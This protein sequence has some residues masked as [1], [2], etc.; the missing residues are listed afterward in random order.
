MEG[1]VEPLVHKYESYGPG[2]TVRLT[3]SPTQNS[4]SPLATIVGG[5][6]EFTVTTTGSDVAVHPLFGPVTVTV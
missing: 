2:S 1:V 3:L 4:V 6:V 5:V